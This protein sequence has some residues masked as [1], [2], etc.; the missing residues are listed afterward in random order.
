VVF[1]GFGELLF[2][3]FGVSGPVI[4]SASRFFTEGVN[5]TLKID[6]KPALDE[7]TLDAR[8][9]RDFQLNKN[10]DFIN[11]LNDL[12]P[13]ALIPI[14]VR[15]SGISPEKKVNS[16]TKSERRKLTRLIKSLTLSVSGLLGFENAII[17]R[18]G[19]NVSEVSPR[20][21]E[22]KIVRGLFFAGEILDV[23]ALT[24]GYNLQIAFSTGYAAGTWCVKEG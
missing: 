18:G 20:S 17:T 12:L 3:H 9:L 8:I 22:S 23:D 16:I 10:K 24:G 6:L 19:V 11:S 7:Q 14:I 5:H 4:L 15:I 1:S 2:T 13:R 21:C